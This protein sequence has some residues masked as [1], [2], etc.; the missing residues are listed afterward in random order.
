MSLE[1]LKVELVSGHP[2]TGAYNSDAELAASQLNAANIP[3]VKSLTSN[4]LLAWAAQSGRMAKIKDGI[5]NGSTDEEKSLCE[6]AYLL[7]SR[8]NTELDLNK[9][10]R[11]GMVAALVAFGRLSQTDSDALYVMATQTISRAEELGLGRVYAGTVE[12]ARAL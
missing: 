11:A 12:Q 1:A 2:V 6:A 5:L 8:D 4:E 10:D 9:P 7:I 3:N